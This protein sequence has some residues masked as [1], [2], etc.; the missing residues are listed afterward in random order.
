MGDKRVSGETPGDAGREETLENKNPAEG[1]HRTKRKIKLSTVFWSVFIGLALLFAAIEVAYN[2]L[3]EKTSKTVQKLEGN[4]TI[5]QR[6]ERLKEEI[7]R[8]LEENN[9]LALRRAWEKSLPQIEAL[10]RKNLSEVKNYIDRKLE[11]Y[12]QV[13]IVRSGGIDRFLDWLYSTKTQYYLTLLK[14]KELAER[15]LNSVATR[16]ANKTLF[17]ATPEVARYIEEHFYRFVLNPEDLQGYIDREIVPYME[18]KFSEFQREVLKIVETRYREELRNLTSE[19]FGNSTEI[20]R[21]VSLYLQTHKGDMEKFLLHKVNVIATLKVGES[22]G[23]TLITYKV[24]T[25]ISAKVSE[26]VALKLGEKVASKAVGAASGFTEGLALCAW[27]GPFDLVCAVGGA[28]IATIATDYAVNKA[29]EYLTREKTK[30]HLLENLRKLETSLGKLLYETYRGKVEA[31][32]NHLSEEFYKGI[33][34]RELA[35]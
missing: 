35:K 14:G 3:E 21:L 29:D 24:L 23:L 20:Q 7:F 13:R 33:P 27:A 17:N 8:F 2:L 28:V 15:G 32:E 6:G 16:L 18:K 30:K 25:K 12:F 5:T 34:L 4:K 9:R 11:L 26:K 1:G 19:R 22:V 10:K 31:F